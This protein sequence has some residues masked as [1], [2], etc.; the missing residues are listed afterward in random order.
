MVRFLLTCM[1]GGWTLAERADPDGA[2]RKAARAIGPVSSRVMD[3]ADRA[4]EVIS[5][6]GNTMPPAEFD[7]YVP[8]VKVTNELA[9]RNAPH[10]HQNGFLVRTLSCPRDCADADEPEGI[11]RT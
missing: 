11:A 3:A 5:F 8:M 6:M 2:L 4:P 7:N 10:F 9:R 1:A